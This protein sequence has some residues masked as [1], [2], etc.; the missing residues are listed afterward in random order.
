MKEIL[1]EAE[2]YRRFRSPHIIRLLDSAV[3]QDEESGGK[4]VYL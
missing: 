4:I 1:K 2:A 3:V